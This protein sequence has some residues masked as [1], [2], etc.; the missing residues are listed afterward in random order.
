[1]TDSEIAALLPLLDTTRR[2]EAE[3]LYWERLR[4]LRDRVVPHFVRFYG[5]AKT[6]QGRALLVSKLIQYSRTHE[7][8]YGLGVRALGDPSRHVRHKACA[9]LAYAQRPDALPSLQRL[10]THA[11][12]H[13]RED[14]EHAIRAIQARNYRL[15]YPNHVWVVGDSDEA[16]DPTPVIETRIRPPAQKSLGQIA[17]DAAKVFWPFG[18]R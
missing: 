18:R 3:N 5:E 10:L 17:I 1:M 13:T 9:M 14:A 2:T 8:A 12:E 15:F 7:D 6:W 4:P 11:N 16:L